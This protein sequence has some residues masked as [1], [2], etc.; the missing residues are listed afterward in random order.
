MAIVAAVVAALPACGSGSKKA[1]RPGTTATT[2]ARRPT[3]TASPPGSAGPTVKLADDWPTYGH[4]ARRT[5]VGGSGPDPAK[6]GIKW[7]SDDLDGLLYAQPLVV[8]DRVFAATQ[9]DTVYALDRNSG[10]VVWKQT[11]GQPVP[12][13]DLPCG[14]IDPSG[15]TATPVIDT[16]SKTIFVVAFMQPGRHE[17]VALDVNSGTVRFRRPIAPAGDDPKA[18]QERAALTIANG[19]VYVSMGGLFG[20]CGRYHGSVTSSALD[21]QGDVQFFQVPTDREGALWSPGGA[22][23]D[24]K[25]NLFV[26]TGNAASSTTY[27]HGNSVIRLTPDLKLADAWA[28]SDF[29]ARSSADADVGSIGPVLLNGDLVFQ[30]AKSGDGFLLRAGKLGGI[31]GEAFRGQV[32]SAAFGTAAYRDPMVFVPCTDGIAALQLDAAPSFSVAWHGPRAAAGPPAIAGDTVWWLST[33]SGE[34][35]GSAV[36]DGHE[37][38]R[39]RVGDL[40]S[41][42]TSPSVSGGQVF[43][44]AGRKIVAVAS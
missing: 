37:V 13:A 39:I 18:L 34:L 36:A 30:S 7:S 42:F 26:T 11:V 8:G 17:L 24:A 3:V 19:R 31:G 4:D 23:V 38:A 1:A 22:V 32:C 40:P 2:I 6:A 43:V 25:G 10:K 41:Q 21:G 12:R 9:N 14:N 16:A 20:D 29:A 27:D 35:V 5:G 33:R 44:P 28:P 15:I